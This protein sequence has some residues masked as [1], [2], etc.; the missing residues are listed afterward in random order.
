MRLSIGTKLY[1]F[2]VNRIRN[3]KELGCEFIEMTHDK[4]GA[5]LCW[6][7]NK[8]ENKLFS[9]TFKTLPEDST[10]VFH[11]LE[12]SVLCGSDKYPVKEPFV[13]LMKS[14]VN[15]FLNAIT[16]VDKT[17]YP[18]SSRNES[19]YL[20]LASVYLDLVF[21]PALLN[22]PNIFYQEGIHTELNDGEPSYKGVVFSEM[23]GSTAGLDNKVWR[24]LQA[25]IFPNNCYRFNSGGDP[26]VIP[27]LTYEQC[28]DTYKRYYHPS[29]SRFFL[30][31]DI[32]LEKTLD[33]INSYLEKYEKSDIQFEVAVQTPVVN[34]GTAYYE[35]AP[36][37]DGSRKAALALGKIVA[38]W[39][40]KEKIYAAM[41]L[42]E[43]LAGSNEAPLKRA[44]LSS[45]LADDVEMYVTD[46]R[47]QRPFMLIIKNSAADDADQISEVIENTVKKLL[48]EGIDKKSILASINRLSFNLKESLEPQGL[49][50]LFD[51]FS[52]WN[53]GGDPLLYLENDETFKSLRKMAQNGGFEKLLEE[54][55]GDL[56]SLCVLRMLPS[57]TFEEKQRKT[58][59]DR[60]QREITALTD[61][62]RKGLIGL[63]EKLVLWQQTPDSPEA[64]AT[65]PTL[66]LSA[67]KDDPEALE[68]RESTVDGV[69]AL[70]H[71][72]QTNGIVY[73]TMYFPLTA[74]S[75]EELSQLSL[76]PS[77]L[78]ELPTEKHTAAQ[79]QQEIKTYIGSLSFGMEAFAK[80]G[81]TETCT[82][83]HIAKAGIL[84]ENL[85][86]AQ[87]L[88]AEILTETRFEDHEKIRG[89]LMQTYEQARQAVVADGRVMGRRIVDAHYSAKAAVNEAIDGGYSSYKFVRDFA[90]NYEANIEDFVSLARRAQSEAIGRAGLVISVISD[91][92][93]AVDKLLNLL[94]EGKE[95]PE[96]TAYKTELPEKVGIRIPTQI[97]FAVKGCNL[98]KEGRKATGSLSV[99]SKILA[100]NYLWN[101]VRVQGGAYG[102][103]FPVS[104]D[105]RIACTSFC[106]PS[107]GRTLGIF[108]NLSAFLGEFCNGDEELDKFIIS[109]VA[110]TEP[111]R[112]PDEYRHFVDE[113]WFLGVTFEDRAKTRREMLET[114]REDLEDWRS[115]FE[116]MAEN[117]A[118]C[119]VGNDD[120]LNSCGELTVFDL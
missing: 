67:V 69:T 76:L 82:P 2:T 48:E 114:T 88:I 85:P 103:H 79:L 96:E 25:L 51:V 81:N 23:K 14:S 5:E 10:G 115:A 90:K 8:E 109:A 44:I 98:L 56:N 30:D 40:E 75:L 66:P 49:Y 21:A 52:S 50:R 15:T 87:T 108:D 57:H 97:A 73:L 55:L 117:G 64:M 116:K 112:D 70:Y 78:G 74:F 95:S 32:P 33:M 7:D 91:G 35:I 29:N 12:H 120:A 100:L 20:N 47:S 93:I 99:A 41:I 92:E 3:S 68:T 28:V 22:N 105:G 89:L 46:A 11:I 18:V 26:A 119:V 61:E 111:L 39:D 24:E 80:D 53:Y 4:T 71:P 60:L 9:V 77:L 36:E 63:N 16:F 106:D 43:V 86:I 38:N 58:E 31:G 13:E 17:A 118:V 27:D 6:V 54:M 102:V 34:K 65:L 94:P 101:E 19:D 59:A 72:L 83:Y 62:E 42:C 1:G 110:A 113:Q 104:Q 107:P 45:N 84:K 37:E